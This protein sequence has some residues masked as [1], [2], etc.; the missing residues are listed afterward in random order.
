M[1]THREAMKLKKRLTLRSRT[2]HSFHK[3][4]TAG[5]SQGRTSFATRVRSNTQP[6]SAWKK[7][8]SVL[9]SKDYRYLRKDVEKLWAKFLKN[10]IVEM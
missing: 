9:L 7:S 4:R 5:G 8:L 3:G 2:T 10:M 6:T 1:K